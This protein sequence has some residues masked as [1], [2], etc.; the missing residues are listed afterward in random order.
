MITKAAVISHGANAVRYATEKDKAEIIKLNLLARR[1]S[2]R[3]HLAANGHS[4]EKV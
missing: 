1:C 4:S 2:A 3:R